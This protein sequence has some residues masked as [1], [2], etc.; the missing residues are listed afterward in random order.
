MYITVLSELVLLS[1]ASALPLAR[2][3]ARSLIP[4]TFVSA[5]VMSVALFMSWVAVEIPILLADWNKLETAT[6]IS[7]LLLNLTLSKFIAPVDLIVISPE[8]LFITKMNSQIASPNRTEEKRKKDSEVINELRKKIDIEKLKELV[9]K[10]KPEFWT[11]R[12]W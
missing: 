1:I 11:E 3:S 8:A 6:S 12:K 7:V 2:E 10:L 9:S 5:S 4:A